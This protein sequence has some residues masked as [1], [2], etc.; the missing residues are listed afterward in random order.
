[1]K[2]RS[3]F[4][5]Q[6]I[7]LLEDDLQLSDTI[8]QFL[9]YKDYIVFPA[10]DA[11]EAKDIL[12]EKKVDLMLLDVKVPYQN[13][14]DFLKEIRA[15]S[16]LTPAIFI[17]SLNSVDNVERG[18]DIGCDDYIRKPFALK[19]LLVRIEVIFKRQLSTYEESI[20]LSN[21]YTFNLEKSLLLK[22]D[23]IV[24]IRTKEL[25]LLRFFLKNSNK[26]FS[27]DEIYSELWD[28]SE[29]P[30]Q[31]SLRAYISTIR[32]I[33]G[34]DKIETIKHIGYRYVKQ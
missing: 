33:I 2:D 28:Y 25:K 34:K 8:K 18:F 5:K 3:R 6:T 16:N 9:E 23:N 12:Y 7:L 10:Y 19:E 21:G 11:Y 26:L 32:N 14:F 15:D 29:T 30:S 24:T 20:D 4:T 17:T 27:Y 31:G 1:M 13:G 22:N